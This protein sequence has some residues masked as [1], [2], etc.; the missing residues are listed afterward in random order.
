MRV[1]QLISLAGLLAAGL[2]HAQHESRV[3][4]RDSAVGLN[5]PATQTVQKVYIVQMK[6]PG[7]VEHHVTSF[8][9]AAAKLGTLLRSAPAFR[10][11]QRVH[12]ELHAKARP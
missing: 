8:G 4:V 2:V 5:L 7:A 11:E 1:G 12:A 9:S 10:Q 3:L 6:T